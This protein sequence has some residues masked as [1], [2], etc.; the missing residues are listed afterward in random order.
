MEMESGRL[1]QVGLLHGDREGSRKLLEKIKPVSIIIMSDDFKNLEDL[2][3]LIEW[4]KNL[5]I[6]EFKLREP[7]I[8]VDQEGG[9]V[10]R[11]REI[12]YP[13]SNYALGLID[14]ENISYYS[15]A[16]TGKE[17]H[18]LGFHWDLDLLLM[19]FQIRRMHLFWRGHSVNMLIRFQE[20]VQHS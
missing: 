7:L 15:G 1:M 8:A 5:Y 18:D 12:N 4:I 14:N 13:P 11:I 9:N 6:K 10:A 16:I 2:S 17:L 20:M 3:E 19:F